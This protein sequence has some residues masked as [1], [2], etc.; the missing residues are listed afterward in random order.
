MSQQSLLFSEGTASLTVDVPIINDDDVESPIESFTGNLQLA[1][2]VS[3]TL[4]LITVPEATVDIVEDDGKKL[5]DVH[6]VS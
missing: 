1:A 2:G 3:M 4:G 6:E 5:V